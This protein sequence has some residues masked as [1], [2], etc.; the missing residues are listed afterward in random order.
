MV[1]LPLVRESN[2]RLKSLSNPVAV[3]V[4]ATQGIGLSTLQ[5]YAALTRAPKIYIVGRSE[6]VGARIIDDL[7]ASNAEGSYV[8]LK[9]QI[10]LLESVDEVCGEIKQR[11]K[12]LDLLFM[13]P[14]YLSFG[15]REETSEG[16]DTLLTVRY[17]ARALFVVRLLPLLQNSSCARVVSVL[18]AGAEGAIF[19]DDFELK[20]HYSILNCANAGT[21][22]TSLFCEEAAARTRVSP[23]CTPSQAVSL[24]EVGERSVFHATSARY[25]ARDA[26]ADGASTATTTAR[27]EATAAWDRGSEKIPGVPL[28]DGLNIANGAGNNGRVGGGAYLVGWNGEHRENKVMVGFRKEGMGSKVWEHTLGVFERVRGS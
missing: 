26:L 7:K 27:Q 20:H 24:K 2:S 21:T 28:P 6:P 3:F 8:F 1:A 4:G 11:E 10:S 5:Q 16:L 13:S 25:P 15:G 9:A 22:M 19:P 17:Y 14:G 18:A 23:L 12:R